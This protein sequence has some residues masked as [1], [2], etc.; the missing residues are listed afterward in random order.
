MLSCLEMAEVDVVLENNEPSDKP[1]ESMTNTTDDSNMESESAPTDMSN[2]VTNE[3][4]SLVTNED[5]SLATNGDDS[6][7]QAKSEMNDMQASDDWASL[8]DD[9]VKS[10]DAVEATHESETSAVE[11]EAVEET[12]P[13]ADAGIVMESSESGEKEDDGKPRRSKDAAKYWALVDKNRQDFTS[14]TQLIAIVEKE[15][16]LEGLKEVY[17]EFLLYYPFCYGYWKKLADFMNKEKGEEEAIQ[18]YEAAVLAVG[19]SIDLWVAYL[20]F[21]INSG[22]TEEEVR[23]LFVRA[24]HSCGLEFKSDKV[25]DMYIDWEAKHN[26]LIQITEIYRQLLSTPTKCY[27]THYDNI[28]EHIDKHE[29]WE[30]IPESKLPETRI[31]ATEIMATRKEELGETDAPPGEETLQDDTEIS[32]E[33]F[34]NMND[35]MKFALKSA[36]QEEFETLLSANEKEVKL[37]WEFEEG[38][39]R[40]YFHNKPLDSAQLKNWRKYLDFEIANGGENR[41]IFLFERCVIAC[42]QYEEF[43][44]KYTAYLEGLERHED[45]RNVYT[46]ACRQHLPYKASIHITWAFYEERQGEYEQALAVISNIELQTPDNMCV[47]NH[48]LNLLRRHGDDLCDLFN[49]YITCKGL[50]AESVK[51]LISKYAR[52]LL[53][54][55]GDPDKASEVLRKALEENSAHEAFYTQLL[56]VEYQ[57]QPLDEDKVLDVFELINASSLSPEVKQKFYSR[58]YE[59][60]DDLGSDVKRLYSIYQEHEEAA[61]AAKEKKRALSASDKTYSDPKKAKTTAQTYPNN[62]TAMNYNQQYQQ[63]GQYYG[64]QA[65]GWGQQYYQQT[66]DYN[67]YGYGQ[68]YPQQQQQQAYGTGGYTGYDYSGYY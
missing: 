66:Q 16:Q 14:W 65:A 54:I 46:R 27:T 61:T 37:R 47:L 22:K 42:A 62:G 35:K 10:D 17:D 32:T 33:N 50:G 58:R 13:E 63:Q 53:K 44:L 36:L 31:R 68:Q 39:K 40:P 11:P 57:R 2:H 67:Q 45:V 6:E 25:W 3:D 49:S 23:E 20:E 29:P 48:K 30:I 5:E 26:N 41:A 34:E 18:V 21:Y 1:I 24:I 15:G 12:N 51:L 56:D 19:L 7:V 38:V 55:K 52:Y 64:G 9:L 59:F 60:I 8:D 4:E 43:W 28:K